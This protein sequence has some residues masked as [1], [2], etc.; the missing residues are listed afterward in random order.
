MSDMDHRLHAT[1]RT[2]TDAE[3]V[4][5][6]LDHAGTKSPKSQAIA[7][8]ILDERALTPLDYA[9]VI[10]AA[11]RTGELG[12]ILRRPPR[13]ARPVVLLAWGVALFCGAGGYLLGH[14]VV[15]AAFLAALGGVSG[16]FVA[17]AV[18]RR[19]LAHQGLGHALRG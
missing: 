6:V 10:E 18:R 3:L 14:E 4:D 7:R 11:E 5:M 15:L 2:F 8:Q 1:F 9:A 13:L 19:Y 17:A 12:R 16:A